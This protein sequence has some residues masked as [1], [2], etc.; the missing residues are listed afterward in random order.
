MAVILGIAAMAGCS[1]Q[2]D[3]PA[4]G[5]ADVSM[6]VALRVVNN[7]TTSADAAISGMIRLVGGCVSLEYEDGELYTIVGLGGGRA[8]W[9]PDTQTVTIA[10][11]GPEKVATVG[12]FAELSGF[13]SEASWEENYNS[14]LWEVKPN[15]NCPKKTLTV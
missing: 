10:R 3:V 2:D 12:E 6:P 11:P 8:T 7:S 14:S 4:V 9:N 13:L 1:N 5:D 15:A